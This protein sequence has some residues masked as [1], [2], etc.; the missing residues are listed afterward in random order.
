MLARSLGV[1]FAL[2]A[3]TVTVACGVSSEGDGRA[4]EPAEAELSASASDLIVSTQEAYEAAAR[5]VRPGDTIVLED[6]VWRDFDMVIDAQ[7]SAEAPITVRAKTPG[8]VV[9]SGR[10]SLRIAGRHVVVSGLV[11]RDGYTPR[12]EVISF[13]RDADNLAFNSRVTQTVIEGYSNPERARGDIWVALYGRDNVF[14]RNHLAGKMNAGPTLAVRLD[15][16][17]SRNNNHLISHNYFGPRAIFGSNGGETLRIGTS[18]FSLTH[19]G[20]RVE[21]NFFD[22]CSG[23]V[24]IVSNKSGGNIF[25]SNTF[26]KSRGTLTLRHGGDTLVEKNLFDGDGAPYTGGV[27]VIN[28][29]QTVRNNRFLN[30]AGER[31]SGALVVM[32]GVPNSPINRYHQVDGTVIE[33]N[34]FEDIVRI[35][36]GEGADPERSAAPINS[37]FRDN[38]VRGVGSETPF[39]LHDDMSGIA[40]E[41]NTTNAPPPPAIASGFSVV[42]D[43]PTSDA[44]PVG[45]FG[46]ARDDTGVD[47]FAKPGEA[48]LF[49][50]GRIIEVSPA[51]DALS[52]AMDLAAA[53]DTLRLAP[54]L[55]AESK[56]IEVRAPVSIVAATAGD[57]PVITFERP[58]LF[59]LSRAGALH[60]R[61]V[62]VSGAAASDAAGNSFITTSTA[63]G[64]KNHTVELEDMAFEQFDVNRGFSVIKASKGA[65]YDRIAIVRSR[66]EDVSGSV[67]KLDPE[68]DDYGIYNAEY[69]VIE[70]SAFARI[71]GPV[72]SVY[73]GGRDESTFGPHVWVRGSRFDGVGLRGGSLM[74][75]HGV[76]NLELTNNTVANARPA[77]FVITTGHPRVLVDAN[78]MAADGS[79]DIVETTDLRARP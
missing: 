38:S 61:G 33:R 5:T 43:A 19:S 62:T 41:G 16:E 29:R 2:A 35:E 77:A 17:Q 26:H 9:L 10:S 72:V 8:G 39:R 40:F 54:G 6:G 68:T 23:E 75:L 20:T 67:V 74:A 45:A 47:W 28:P 32:N 71:G 30:L 18:H 58:N 53:G 63:G 27:R 50:G 49:E 4:V 14:D 1:T 73:R 56:L 21:H 64:A 65:F 48:A 22:R 70:D 60:M 15:S 42:A 34:V 7:G 55:Y 46:V 12:A 3:A 24:E 52:A 57:R 69:V 31:F 36:L 25:R 44:T 13:R 78:V 79:P 59:V 51:P 11:F 37:I 76:Q 66:F